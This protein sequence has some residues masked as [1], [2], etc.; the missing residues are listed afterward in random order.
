MTLPLTIG[1]APFVVER[2][3]HRH[4]P[5]VVAEVIVAISAGGCTLR[6]LWHTR[7][8]WHLHL[9]AVVLT[10]VTV[11]ARLF[12]DALMQKFA[13]LLCTLVP[14]VA[15]SVVGPTRPHFIESG[16]VVTGV[17]KTLSETIRRKGDE[18][19][20]GI[21]QIHLLRTRL[22]RT[23]ARESSLTRFGGKF[24]GLDAV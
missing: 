1:T 20:L 5:R 8:A 16:N 24:F 7:E 3:I 11:Q 6:T 12:V 21:N 15:A 4:T 10:L 23:E 22:L 14:I 2:D 9:T 17:G 13:A 19:C 18:L